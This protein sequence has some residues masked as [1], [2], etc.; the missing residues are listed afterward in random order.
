MARLWKFISACDNFYDSIKKIIVV[1]LPLIA[2][3]LINFGVF[4]YVTMESPDPETLP[5]GK[6][7]EKSLSLLTRKFVSLLLSSKNGI[8]DLKN[9]SIE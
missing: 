2:F 4:D 5:D 6:R 9:V 3:D 8:L 7:T 1:H